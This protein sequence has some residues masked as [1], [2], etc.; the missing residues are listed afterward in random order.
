M[1]AEGRIEDV[2]M[3]IVVLAKL[4]IAGSALRL[5]SCMITQYAASLGRQ[6][7]ASPRFV[8]NAWDEASGQSSKYVSLQIDHVGRWHGI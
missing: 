8:W 6:S 4:G 5:S 7:L 1:E 2:P 3:N